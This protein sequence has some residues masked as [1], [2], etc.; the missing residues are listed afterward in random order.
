MGQSVG[1]HGSVVPDA[2]WAVLHFLRIKGMVPVGTLAGMTGLA[3]EAVVEILGA[4]RAADHAAHHE[5]RDLWHLTAG[6][7]E[8]HARRLA[9]V[10]AGRPLGDLDYEAFLALND[11]FK[12]LCTDWQLRDGAPND[13]ADA[14]HDRR[15]LDRLREHDDRARTVI[16]GFP[17]V[18]PWT[19]RYAERLAA[20]CERAVDGD[21]R[22][23]TGVLCDSYHDIWME[24]HED[25][26]LSQG[27]D[28][29]AEGS[30]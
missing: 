14:D 9:E 27:I 11:S 4:L 12:A 20:A 13:H 24:L 3:D 22:A 28:R 29:A 21:H 2:D 15:V 1:G 23:F 16:A 6:G 18:L 5:G 10:V 25:L 30:T 7:R 26:I 19:C 8:E 17:A